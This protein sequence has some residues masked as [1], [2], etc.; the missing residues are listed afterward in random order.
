MV[1]NIKLLLVVVL[2]DQNNLSSVAL[3]SE[4]IFFN[5]LVEV[6]VPLH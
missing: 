3:M 6:I 4:E 5:A 2:H 1:Y